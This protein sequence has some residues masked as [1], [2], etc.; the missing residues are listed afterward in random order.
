MC[1]ASYEDVERTL[2]LVDLT[3]RAAVPVADL[4]YG[5]KRR[6]EIGLAL[7]TAPSVLL[8][9]EP[10]AG[11][12]PQERADTIGLLKN[13][14]KGRT[15]VLV[16]HDMDAVFDLA[17]RI[18]V[19]YEGRVL[20]EGTPERNPGQQRRP[21]R[22]SRRS[23]RR[24]SLLEVDKINSYYGDSHILFDV[25]MRVEAREVV[26]LL[27]RNGAGK[28]TT[29]RTL[30]GVVSPRSGS[31]RLDGAPIEGQPPFAIARRGVQLVPEERRIFGSL[32]VEENLDLASPHRARPLAAGAHLRDLP[33]PGRAA[34]QPRHRSLGRRAADAGH[35]PRAD[36]RPEDHPARRALRGPGA[37]HRAAT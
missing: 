18:T 13:I 2:A 21:G 17:E 25:S 30:M 11:M 37:D 9:D 1:P 7:A 29:L 22:L 14:R 23:A 26:A 34:P 19:L 15:L 27:G 24:M 36:P 20:A 32:S 28:T 5:E 10:L 33:A 31:I 8:L 35:R 3:A 4:A 16:E 6:L 12:S